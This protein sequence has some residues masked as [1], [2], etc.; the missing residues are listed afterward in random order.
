[1]EVELGSKIKDS[2]TGFKGITTAR[3]VYINGCV[4]YE[5]T[6]TALKDGVPQKEY[7]LDE[8]RVILIPTKKKISIPSP[9]SKYQGGP[10]NHPTK[11]NPPSLAGYEG[12]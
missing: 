2:V 12:D 5:I 4:Q 6:P 9:K 8:K 11:K 3:C 7:W 10:A 1:M